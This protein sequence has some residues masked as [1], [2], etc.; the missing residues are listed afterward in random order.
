MFGIIILLKTI[1]I[2][3]SIW[4]KWEKYF[5]Q[6]LVDIKLLHYPTNDQIRVAPLLE[7]PAQELTVK[8][9][10]LRLAWFSRLSETDLPMPFEPDGTMKMTSLK[11]SPFF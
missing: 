7:I 4:S 8:G 6:N 9:C 11:S 10:L 2:C 3:K 5:V 1:I